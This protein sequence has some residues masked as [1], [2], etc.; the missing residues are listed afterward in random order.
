MKI[1]VF[2]H[3]V[4]QKYGD[5]LRKREKAGTLLSHLP[6]YWENEAVN[7]LDVRLRVLDRYPGVMQVLTVAVSPLETLV[8]P[9]DAIELAR[10]A[11]DEMA[12]LVLMKTRR[13]EFHVLARG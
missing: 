5:E 4:P 2:S 9:S 11:N 10:M 6:D 1:D 3:I 8:S 12:E 7:R 13:A